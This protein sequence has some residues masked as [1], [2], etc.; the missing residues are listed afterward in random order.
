M[1]PSPH[2]QAVSGA[3]TPMVHY[4]DFYIFLP[5]STQDHHH[6][7]TTF[8]LIPLL[9]V[10]PSPPPLANQSTPP[11]QSNWTAMCQKIV[12]FLISQVLGIDAYI[13]R[14]PVNPAVVTDYYEKIAKPICLKQ[15]TEK[16]RNGDYSGPEGFYND[17]LLLC[18]NCYKYNV[19][20]YPSNIGMLGVK[21]ENAF[22]GAWSKT[23]FSSS[24]IPR[25]F[26]HPPP[27]RNLR[28]PVKK[29]PTMSGGRGSGGQRSRAARG[30]PGRPA[31]AR[32]KSVNSYGAMA[33]Y[34]PEMQAQLVS[35]LNDAAVLEANMDGVVAILN[36]AGEMGVDEEGEATLDLEKVTP[37]T[38]LKLYD[39]VV[40][41]T[42]RAG[43]PAS[44]QPQNNE[45]DDWDPDEEF[46]E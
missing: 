43:I 6:L 35:A 15:I 13:F 40:V 18:D 46:D 14:D 37:P 31:V 8:S 28:Q 10:A 23:P 9:V 45:D 42:G 34:T 4:I 27:I 5:I 25:P 12:D 29:T 16:L 19:E 39:L 20:T 24:V 36:Q 32:T 7:I 38:A 30:R 17:M 1:D 44:Q 22:L 41:K 26:R 11:L 2:L 3:L 21:M 33:V